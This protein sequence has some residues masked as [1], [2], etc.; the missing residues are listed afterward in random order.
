M[1]KKNLYFSVYIKNEF[2]NDIEIIGTFN[3]MKEL[4]KFFEK[5]KSYLYS[6]GVAKHKDLRIEIKLNGIDYAIIVDQD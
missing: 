4:E 2:E 3:D 6:L 5:S 1:E